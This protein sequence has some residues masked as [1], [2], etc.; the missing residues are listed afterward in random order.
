M[1]GLYKDEAGKETAYESYDRAMM[2]WPVPYEEVW[3]ETAY[4]R[5][6]VVISGEAGKKPLYLLP[7][8]FADATMWYANIGE[9]SR[10]CRVYCL[11]Y[12]NCGGKSEPSG[13]KV[14]K[15]E[16]YAVWFGQIMDVLAG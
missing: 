1:M 15:V 5:S 9:L 11:D 2:L 6:H 10:H 13:K 14:A 4:G 12:I 3:V 8:L 7:G 16:D